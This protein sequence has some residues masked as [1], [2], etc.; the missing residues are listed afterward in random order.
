M[1]QLK[2]IHL[3]RFLGFSLFYYVLSTVIVLLIKNVICGEPLLSKY[4]IFHGLLRDLRFFVIL[5]ALWYISLSKRSFTKGI[6]N[7][8]AIKCYLKVSLIYFAISVPVCAI[9]PYIKSYISFGDAF[10]NALD[11]FRSVVF[12]VTI[13]VCILWTYYREKK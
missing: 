3:L 13:F 10:H 12:I 6:K 5:F 4:T 1:P 7:A 2:I 11:G 9:V 8:D